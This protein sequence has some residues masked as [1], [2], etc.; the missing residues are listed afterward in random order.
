LK[1]TVKEITSQTDLRK[2]IK[3]PN[4][5]YEGNKFYV[6]PLNSAEMETLSKD[7]N[8]AFEFCEAKYWLVYNENNTIV[9]RIAGIVNHKYNQKT[10]KQYVR[11]GWLD[12]VEDI[13]VL[14]A[15]LQTVETWAKEKNAEYIHGPLGIS[16]FDAAGVI[17]EGFDEMPTAYGKYNYPYYSKDIESLGFEKEVDWVEFSITIPQTMP[18]RFP[19]MAKMIAERYKLHCVRFSSKKEVLKHTNEIFQLLNKEYENIHGFSALSPGQIEALK[20]QFIPLVR[21]KYI[22]VVMNA[23]K[24]VVGFGICLPS[25]SK[26]LQN[27][28]GR[29]F[30]F[31]FLHILKALHYNDTIDSLLIAIHSDY[32]DKGVNALIFNDIGKSIIAD[33]MKYMET[34]R[35]LEH[36]VLVQNLWGKLEYRQH[37][38]ARCYVKALKSI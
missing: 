37:K 3:F 6:P 10:G 32:R 22:S 11:F 34:T 12:Y 19:K 7:K 20:K 18:E 26:A 9:G 16:E 30:P 29:L 36:N 31:G 14:N 35:E 8:P 2:F 21:L 28:K 23:E 17:I 1:Y 24:K 15:L 33:G 38:R 5:L 13:N 4:K 25:L 27:C